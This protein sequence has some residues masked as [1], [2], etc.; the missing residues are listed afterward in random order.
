MAVGAVSDRRIGPGDGTAEAEW[1][2]WPGLAALPELTLETLAPDGARV[3]VV[4]PHPDDEVLAA[5]GLLSLLARRG[6]ACH[7]V[8]VTEGEAS[9]RGSSAWPRERLRLE[10]PLETR[11]ALQRLGLQ[12]AM[13]T[14]RRLALPDG[15]LSTQRRRL[16]KEIKALLRCDDVVVTTWRRD[17]HPDHEATGEAVAEAAAAVGARLVEVPVWAWHWAEPGDPRLPW[18]RAHRL[19]LDDKAMRDKWHAVQSF[20]SQLHADPSTGREPVLPSTSVMRC[21]RSFEVMFLGA[22]K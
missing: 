20:T 22:D 4:A 10:R 13:A 6:R 11:R 17:G 21:K 2:S 16:A 5:G 7:V 18:H 8:S 9:H 14:T 1:L 3:F 12:N 19:V 15:G